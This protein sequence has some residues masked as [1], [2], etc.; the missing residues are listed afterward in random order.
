MAVKGKNIVD[1]MI[2]FIRS[3]PDGVPSYTLAETFLKF[4]N[5]DDRMAHIA[6]AGV[7]TRDH[8]CICDNSGLWFI[9]KEYDTTENMPL[10]K[11]PWAVVYLLSTPSRED[12]ILHASVW[13]PFETPHCLFSE[14]FVD[15]QVLSYEEQE[16]L[17]SDHDA[18]F[19][20]RDEALTHLIEVLGNRTILFLSSRQQRILHSICISM[21]ESIPDDTMLISQLFQIQGMKIPKPLNLYTCYTQLFNREPALSSAYH[22]GEAFCECVL[23]IL[24]AIKEKGI[25]SRNDLDAYEIEKTL[26]AVWDE[27]KF[28]LEEVSAMSSGP[29]VYGFKNRTGEYIYIGKAKN[30]RRRILS[31]FRNTEESP[32]KLLQ[33][34]QQ[35]HDLTVYPCGSELECLLFEHRLIKKY[36][37]M[38]NS[39]IAI[40]ERKGTFTPLQDCIILLPHAEEDKGMSVWFRKDQKILIKPFYKDFKDA[41][42]LQEHLGIFFLQQR[43]SAQ[44]SDFPEQEIVFRWVQKHRDIVSIVPVYR[45]GSVE[46]I[47]K[48]IKSCWMSS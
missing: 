1:D 27:A 14:W 41:G 26:K 9:R 19:K 40:N 4:K 15:P 28:S 11:T 34:R 3:C 25:S 22:Y 32:E 24:T 12:H 13:T 5:P 36:R 45:M 29:G 16:L 33:L 43:L 17:V 6:V 21:G 48:A 30:I 10:E 7:L 31:Y 47:S 46:E 20:K 38:L 2:A 39:K 18:P 42:D 44:T 8:R 35:A 23:E 37:P